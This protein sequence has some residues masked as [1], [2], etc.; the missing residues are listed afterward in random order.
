MDVLLFPCDFII[1]DVH[2]Y[3]LDENV[4][5]INNFMNGIPGLLN[6]YPHQ[7]HIMYDVSTLRGKT[8]WSNFSCAMK[9]Q[10]LLFS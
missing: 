7:R 1:F 3:L 5:I 10:H 2:L 4:R 8:I 9:A 6:N